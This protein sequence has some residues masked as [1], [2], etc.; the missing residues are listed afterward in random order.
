MFFAFLS[1][2]LFPGGVVLYYLEKG[3]SH[4]APDRTTSHCRKSFQ[5]SN[6]YIPQQLVDCMNGIANVEAV[7][8]DYTAERPFMYAG[9]DNLF[10]AYFHNIPYLQT[11][12][13]YT[14]AHFYEFRNGLLYI[15]VSHNEEIIYTHAFVTSPVTGQYDADAAEVCAEK[16]LSEVFKNGKNFGDAKHEDL[17]IRG[18]IITVVFNALLT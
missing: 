14:Q 11:M 12:H 4:M 7:Y 13:G 18:K 10:E 6:H 9:W 1:M 15:R 17:R 8:I 16:L 3:H 5:G 2:T